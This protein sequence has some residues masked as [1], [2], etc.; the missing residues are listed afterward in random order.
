ML[1]TINFSI[2]AATKDELQKICDDLVSDLQS[3]SK[4]PE[5]IQLN[6]YSIDQDEECV[7]IEAEVVNLNK[8]TLDYL[9]GR[10]KS[11]EFDPDFQQYA[12]FDQLFTENKNMDCFSYL[13]DKL[14]DEFNIVQ[15]NK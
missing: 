14:K 11:G 2:E 10:I 6:Q 7:Y 13:L 15:T 1:Y 4:Q 9:I 5:P 8:D 3:Q 12:Y